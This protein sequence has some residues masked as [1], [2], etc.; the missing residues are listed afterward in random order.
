MPGFSINGTGGVPNGTM[1]VRR[2]YRWIFETLGGAAT[3]QN[4][5]IL[6]KTAARPSH[7]FEEP[8]MHHQQEKVFLAGKH[9]WEAITM[10]WYDAEQP[11]DAS[12][13]IWDWLNTVLAVSEANV[14]IPS[15]YK[16]QGE[17]RMLDGLGAPTETWKLYN[18]WPQSVNW[19]G[20]DYSSTDLQLIEVKYRYDRAV[21]E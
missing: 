9:T 2:T 16:Q 7:S 21:R 13:A 12:K 4:I 5:L 19:N 15:I 17:L 10:T 14:N 1:E 3:P 20:L 18:G 6:L 8:E 11:N